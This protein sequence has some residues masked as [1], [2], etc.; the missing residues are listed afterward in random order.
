MPHNASQPPGNRSVCVG[1]GGGGEE[2]MLNTCTSRE[3]PILSPHGCG[4]SVITAAACLFVVPPVTHL[5]FFYFP[6][7]L[8]LTPRPP[9]QLPHPDPSIPRVAETRRGPWC[10]TRCGQSLYA[11]EQGWDYYNNCHMVFF[12]GPVEWYSWLVVIMLTC[13]RLMGNVFFFLVLVVGRGWKI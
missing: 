12:R 3:E 8:S 10:Q 1:G 7:S 6:P 2:A 13:L 9:T 4:C 11:G 5:L